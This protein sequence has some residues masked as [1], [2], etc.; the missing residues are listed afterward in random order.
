MA[1]TTAYKKRK[2]LELLAA[3]LRIPE[4]AKELG[5]VPGCIV[6]WRNRDEEFRT[7]FDEVVAGF[8]SRARAAAQQALGDA[9]EAGEEW[10]VKAQMQH[11][12]RLERLREQYKLAKAEAEAA[13]AQRDLLAALALQAQNE[14]E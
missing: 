11:L 7:Q 2:A 14:E 9:C 8:D 10:A 6:N 4:V 13:N 12:H 1:N 3:G 5:V